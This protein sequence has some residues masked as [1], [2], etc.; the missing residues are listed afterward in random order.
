MQILFRKS[1]GGKIISHIHGNNKSLNSK[2][3][4]SFAFKIAAKKINKII[5][6]SD[7]AYNDFYYKEK[8]KS[9]SCILYNVVDYKEIMEK[10]FIKNNSINHDLV[11]IGRLDYPKNPEKLIEIAK[12]LKEKKENISIG[13]VGEGTKR[14]KIERIINECDLTKCIKMYG[15][16]ENPF[17]ILK[18]SK[19]LIMTSEW[20]GTP[21]VA[22]EAQALGKPIVSTPVDGMKKIVL[23]N[24]NGYLSEDNTE[25]VDKIIEFLNKKTYMELSKNSIEKFHSFNNLDQYKKILDTIYNE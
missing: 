2:N 3:I 21:M 10:A 8:I 20:E 18:K 12:L 7:T 24:K 19:I 11:F 25:L 5:W 17:P 16:Q 4:K 13:I 6:V 1:L 15:Y 9:K 14:E 22:L 23:N